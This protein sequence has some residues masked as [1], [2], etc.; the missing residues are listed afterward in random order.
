MEQRKQDYAN[1]KSYSAADSCGSVEPV[2]PNAVP[3]RRRRHKRRLRRSTSIARRRRLNHLVPD[4]HYPLVLQQLDGRRSLL[5]ISRKAPH[6]EVDALRAELLRRRQLRRVALRN[7]VHDGPF[8][9]QVGP[10]P[11]ARRHLEDDAAQRPNV[12][13]P[14]LTGVLALDHLGRHVHGRARHGLV[15]L[16]GVEVGGHCPPLASNELGG[17][18]VYV[19]DDAVVVQQDVYTAC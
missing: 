8:V 1:E 13:R 7:V 17:A 6:Q 3:G 4:G 2:R 18:K 9:V 10:R 14:G 11:P 12:H 5:R 19:L 15:G 16:G